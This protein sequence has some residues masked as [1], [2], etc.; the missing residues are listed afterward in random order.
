MTSRSDRLRQWAV[1]VGFVAGLIGT[2]A[3]LGIIGTQVQNS[4][5]GALRAG[6][7][8]LACRLVRLAGAAFG[9]AWPRGPKR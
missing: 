7:A 3:G 2:L 5:G 8:A 6:V 4:A 9:G 1:T